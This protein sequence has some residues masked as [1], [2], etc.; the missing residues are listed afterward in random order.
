MGD[1]TATPDDRSIN[2]SDG[3]GFSSQLVLSRMDY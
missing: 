3:I 1:D 2:F